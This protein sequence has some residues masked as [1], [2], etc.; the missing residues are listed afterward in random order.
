MGAEW[1][2]SPGRVQD[3]EGAKSITLSYN[4]P[5][6]AIAA[7]FKRKFLIT[8]CTY[9]DTG[10]LSLDHVLIAGI[11]AKART[12]AKKILIYDS[13]IH[14]PLSDLDPTNYGPGTTSKDRST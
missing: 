3:P 13:H 8:C 9:H 4:S 14:P 7:I 12:G 11:R 6:G 10:C 1:A 5:A 2:M